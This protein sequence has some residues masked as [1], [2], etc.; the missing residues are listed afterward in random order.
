MSVLA[1]GVV[2]CLLSDVLDGKE[3]CNVRVVVKLDPSTFRPYYVPEATISVV[4]E[5]EGSCGEA[6]TWIG[7]SLEAPVRII[8]EI[9]NVSVSV[10]NLSQPVCVSGYSVEI[11]ADLTVCPGENE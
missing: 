1:V 3:V 6:D 10:Y 2:G 4:V 8:I 11:E 9:G 7:D 5:V